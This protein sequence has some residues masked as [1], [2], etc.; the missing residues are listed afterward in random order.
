MHSTALA[1]PTL[2]REDFAQ[3]LT[4]LPLR[5]FFSLSARL[6]PA[7]AAPLARR[8]FCKP[9]G[10]RRMAADYSNVP[11]YEE[12]TLAMGKKNS[13]DSPPSH[14]RAYSWRLDTGR[15][16]VLIAHGWAGHGLQ[17]A[18]LVSALVEAG[19]EVVSFD[20]PAH[21]GSS[22]D[23]V[24]LPEFARTVQYVADTLGPFHAVIGHSLGGAATAFA[25]SRGLQVQRAVLIAAPADAEAEVRRFARFL[26]IP[27]GAR[28]EMQRT[29]EEAEG[30]KMT[31]LRAKVVAPKIDTPALLIHDQQDREVS[32]ECALEYAAGWRGSKLLT[33]RGLGHVR[34][35]RDAGVI[36]EVIRFVGTGR[37]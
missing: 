37:S 20:Q 21:G 28:R 13:C 30:V 8:L 25:L 15:P 35:L 7:L 12:I 36:A 16:R 29:I 17:F 27:E 24:T 33:T 34:I 2:R 9:R 5:S 18:A 23:A 14:I 1:A 6:A 26:R 19:Y 22:G 4:L 3:W 10:L 31:E 11:P 32:A